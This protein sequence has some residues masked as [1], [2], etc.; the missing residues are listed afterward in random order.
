VGP[1]AGVGVGTRWGCTVAPA[2]CRVGHG[3]PELE[4]PQ[5]APVGLAQ[6]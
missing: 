4:M 1:D 2:A 5:P 6:R 3:L